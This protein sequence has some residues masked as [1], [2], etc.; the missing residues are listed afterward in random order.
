MSNRIHFSAASELAKAA[1]KVQF[2]IG[3]MCP[4]FQGNWAS[5]RLLTNALRCH[6]SLPWITITYKEED[7][8]EL[9]KDEIG[10]LYQEET[11]LWF[12]LFDTKGVLTEDFVS[13]DP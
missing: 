3:Y 4:F 5:A 10:K 9:D 2:Q 11:H 7:N 8:F 13:F 1:W 12:E 6:W